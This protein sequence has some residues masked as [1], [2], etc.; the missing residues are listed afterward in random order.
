MMNKQTSNTLLM[1]EPVA[2]AGNVQT[3]INNYFQQSTLCCGE[4]HAQVLAHAEF[5]DVVNALRAHGVRVIC[6]RD[7]IDPHTPD[8]IFPNNWVSMHANGSVVLY[9]MYAENRR[10]ERRTDLIDMLAGEGFVAKSIL[11]YSGYE[12]GQ[13]FLE[14][15][16]SMVLDRIN[17][18]AYASLSPRTDLSLLSLFCGDL[19]YTPHSFTSYHTVEGE[20]KEIYHTN[21]MMCMATQYAVVCLDAIDDEFEREALIKVITQTGKELITITEEQMNHFA[22]NMLQVENEQGEFLLAMSETAYRSLSP[23]QIV[24]LTEYNRIVHIPIPT[25]EKLGGGSVRCMLAEVFL[26]HRAM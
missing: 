6:V 11:D 22:G 9:P 23:E 5:M 1:I 17:K 20:R 8:S 10:A 25:I 3:A 15:T 2:F 7:T 21:V 13:R 12:S 16:G 24:R 19:G 18:I 14:G 4:H 26:P